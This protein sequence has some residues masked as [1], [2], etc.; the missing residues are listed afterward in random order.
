MHYF[1]L[2]HAC[3][4][5]VGMLGLSD[6]HERLT[7]VAGFILAHKLNHIT[8][9]DIQRGDRTMRGL[10]RQDIDSI[11]QQLDALGWISLTTGPRPSSPTHWIVNP[12][13][14]QLFAQ[15]AEREAVERAKQRE[16]LAKMFKGGAR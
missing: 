5:Y 8:N 11:F 13:V 2:P 15:R 3:S 16:M 4:F 9:R 14:H 7:A 6:D 12:A 10:E 1:L